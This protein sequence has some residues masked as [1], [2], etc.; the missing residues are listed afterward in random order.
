MRQL[1]VVEDAFAIAGRGT[2]LVPEIDLGQRAS[3]ELTVELR[4]P[5]GSRETCTATAQVPMFSPP[6]QSRVPK[7]VL[8]VP[9]A[10]DAVP[11]GTEVW[12]LSDDL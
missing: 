1:I 11:A 9:V 4:R 8:V 3:Y 12:L 6:Q 10:K 7:H 5:D 2:I